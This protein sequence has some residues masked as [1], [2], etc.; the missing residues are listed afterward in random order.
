MLLSSLPASGMCSPTIALRFAT[1]SGI[2]STARHF[3]TVFLGSLLRS[4]P[5]YAERGCGIPLGN[6]TSQLFANFFLT[7]VD[8]LCGAAVEQVFYVRYMDDMVLVGADKG[9]VL[10][11]KE[12]AVAYCKDVLKLTVPI[13]KTVHLANDPVPFLGY[14]VDIGGFKVLSRTRRRHERQVRTMHGRGC[15]SSDIAQVVQSFS[16]FA[17]LDQRLRQAL[18]ST[19]VDLGERF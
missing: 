7:G 14:L 12:Q 10:D 19:S 11:L 1:Q 9:Q 6:L 5:E 15:R 3:V 16:A 18:S 8:R 4:H 17:N 2:E 13:R